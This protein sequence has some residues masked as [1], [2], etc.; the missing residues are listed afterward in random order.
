MVNLQGADGITTSP[1][2]TVPACLRYSYAESGASIV[3][4]AKLLGH[5]K[6]STTEHYAQLS[7]ARILQAYDA[8]W[9]KDVVDI[10]NS[11]T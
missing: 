11:N 2:P 6:L 8:A 7:T 5:E 4:V 10:V 1:I 9:P 3:L